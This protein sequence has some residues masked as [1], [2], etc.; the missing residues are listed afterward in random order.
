M[1]LHHPFDIQSFYG[2]ELVFLN[3]LRSYFMQMITSNIC[4]FFMIV[5]VEP[6]R[7]PS[8]IQG[9]ILASILLGL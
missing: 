9:L 8:K 7:L 2:D 3:Q 1:I 6:M 4:Y 5:K